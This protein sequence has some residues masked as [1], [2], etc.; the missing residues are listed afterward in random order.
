MPKCI[1]KNVY[2]KKL[3]RKNVKRNAS[4]SKCI[5]EGTFLGGNHQTKVLM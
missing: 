2:E 1:R 3:L 5:K 4:R